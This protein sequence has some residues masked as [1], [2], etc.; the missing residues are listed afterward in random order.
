L[1]PGDDAANAPDVVNNSWGAFAHPDQIPDYDEYFRDMINTWQ[2]AGI[3]PVFA[4]GNSGPFEETVELPALYPEAFSVG[5]TD[6]DNILAE[7]SSR[8]PS[9]KPYN[10]LKP[11]V[12][13]PG[14]DIPS[15]YPGDNYA[16]MGGTSMAAPSVAGVVDL[17]LQANADV[18]IDDLKQAIMDT[19][20]PLTDD[21]YT[22]S[23]NYGYGHGLVD[24]L[25]LVDAVQE[26]EEPE[27]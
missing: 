7:F 6:I 9:P 27:P 24:A 4:A 23:P 20:T 3:F 14:V 5:A 16:M 2:D 11:E 25:A 17:A 12:S 10:S 15:S 21:E 13:A 1:A 26:D 8:G 18:S 19:A 22:E